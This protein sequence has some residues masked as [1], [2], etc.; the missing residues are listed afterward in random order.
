VVSNDSDYVILNSDGYLGHVPINEMVWTAPLQDDESALH[1]DGDDD[2]FQ[3]VTRPKEKK[4]RLPTH[5]VLRGLIPPSDITPGLSLSF[6]SYSPSRLASHLNLPVSLLPL[7]SSFVGND[8]SKKL[9]PHRDLQRLFFN[10]QLTL[11]DRIDHVASTIRSTLSTSSQKRKQ[12]QKVTSIMDLINNTANTL[13]ASVIHT[14]GSGEVQLIVDSVVEATLQYVIP[15]SEAKDGLWP[16]EVCALHEPDL[17]PILPF[18]SRSLVAERVTQRNQV[19]QLYIKAYR[20]G[21]L[22]PALMNIL[23]TGNYWPTLFLEHPDVQSVSLTIGSQ[24]RLWGY[25]I[26]DDALGLPDSEV[27]EEEEKASSEPNDASEDEELVDV[28]GEDSEED[29]LAPL[30][31]ELKR[32]HDSEDVPT[33][34]PPSVLPSRSRSSRQLGPKTVTEYIRRGTRVA[35]SVVTVPSLSDLL[36]SIPDFDSNNAVPLPLRTEDAR[37][38]VLLRVTESDT[39][40]VRALPRDQLIAALTVRW[41]AHAAH[42]QAQKSEGNKDKDI[43]RWTKREAHSL[44]ASFSWSTATPSTSLQ[45]ATPST[46]DTLPSI[47]DRN[48]QLMSQALMALGS[49]EHLSQIL[50]IT[51]RVG[52]IAHRL[53]GQ[54]CHSFWTGVKPLNTDI[55]PHGLWDACLEGLDGAFGEEPRK[56]MK[57]GRN[58]RMEAVTYPGTTAWKSTGGLFG[59]LKNVEI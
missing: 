37:L 51:D 10:R 46:Q 28:T 48:V 17:C 38:A 13:L 26:L 54:R 20:R 59:F 22:S 27:E 21:D 57:K 5:D 24:L 29:W 42:L 11:S 35:A 15:K 55:I 36:S 30:R 6:L 44:L 8:F 58:E 33:D 14:M 53:S 31:G 12:K 9:S 7:L 16:T 4:K 3:L 39:S 1:D 49:I 52:S 47:E 18:F 23:S 50:L 45:A 41:V 40:L 2:D 34:P 56:K 32:L 19:R 25:A 43:Q